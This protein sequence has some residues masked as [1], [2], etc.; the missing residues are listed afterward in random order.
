MSRGSIP[1]GGI[2]I[3]TGIFCFHVVV[4]FSECFVISFVSIASGPLGTH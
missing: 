1:T 4:T 3:V 2:Y